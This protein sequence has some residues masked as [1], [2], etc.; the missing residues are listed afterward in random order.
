MHVLSSSDCL[1]VWESGAGLHPLDQGLLALSAGLPDLPPDVL[2]DWPLGRRNLALAQLRCRSFGPRLFAWTACA[3]CG[4]K[5]E[6]EVDGQLLAGGLT[7]QCQTSE[8][9]VIVNGR[10][11]RLPTTRDLVK[12]A[13]ELDARLASIRLVESCCLDPAQP[14]TWSDDDLEQIGQRLAMADPLA[15]T[16]LALACPACEAE[17]EENLDIILFLW[18]EIEA[19]ARR[20]LFE[21]HTLAS[22]YGWGEADILSLSEHRR[23]HY[24]ELVRS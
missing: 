4:E 7:D 5:L 20:L 19:R 2:A 23:A 10:S 22:A 6:I 18:R 9:P 11:F 24:L 21:I 13:Q 14:S 3:R 16:R 12:A 17:W 1:K 15:E 8:D